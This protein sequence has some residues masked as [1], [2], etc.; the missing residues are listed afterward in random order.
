MNFKTVVKVASTK[1]GATALLLGVVGGA[2]E[3]LNAQT[4]GITGVWHQVL[5]YGVLLIEAYG[6]VPLV[7]RQLGVS[8]QNLLHASPAVMHLIS[9]AGFAFSGAVQTFSISGVWR[10]V[11]VGLAAVILAVF[12]PPADV[13]AG[14][15]R[16]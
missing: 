2:I 12:G 16:R 3:Y 7:G 8:I 1:A 11:L 15:K 14:L 9:L 5:T 4:F 13:P 6:V 10:G